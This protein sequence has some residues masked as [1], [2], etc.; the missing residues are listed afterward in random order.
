MK[1]LDR[2]IGAH[3]VRGFLLVTLILAVLFSFI[4]TVTQL[5]D[6]GKGSYQAL[7]AFAY[8]GLTLPR[9]MLDL[10]PMSALLGSITAMGLLADQNE[11]LAMRAAGLSVRRICW[12]VIGNGALLMLVA[13][14]LAEFVVPAMEQYARQRRSFA[15][16]GPTVLLT[17]RGFWARNGQNLIRVRSTLR[18]GV[19]ADLDIYQRDAE[20]R[21][22]G[23]IRARRAEVD[24]ENR[25]LLTD[26]EQR[27]IGEDG[28]IT[29]RHLPSLAWDSSLLSSKQIEVLG[30]PPHSLSP[31]DLYVHVRALEARGENA[32]HH[33]LALWQK[34]SIPLTTGAMVLLSLPFVFGPP[35]GTS[36]G[37][38]IVLGAAAGIAFYLISQITG[39]V[40]LLLDLH[41]A[42]TTMTP[43]AAAL[44]IALWLMR[45]LP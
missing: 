21:L 26:V 31:S 7:D 22:R 17:E 37:K 4:E 9:R 41:P 14:V 28:I 10:V 5:N 42:F 13:A 38:R 44:C 36:T 34:L 30:L 39:H 2:Y 23:I 6:V 16:S 33:A 27:V 18:G 25:W 24:D 20:G 11:L 1:T 29:T 35:R 3:F 43:V 45:R 8:V 19:P 32:D 15:I 40:G 12:S